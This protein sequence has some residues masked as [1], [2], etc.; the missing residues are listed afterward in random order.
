MRFEHLPQLSPA[1]AASVKKIL[2]EC[3]DEFVPPLSLRTATNSAQLVGGPG[4]TVGFEA[5]YASMAKQAFVLAYDEA[6]DELLAFLTYIPKAKVSYFEGDCAYVST[7]C[8]TA[9]ARGK[10]IAAALYRQLEDILGAGDICLKT[11]STN[12]AQIKILPRLGYQ[13][14]K[15]VSNERGEGIDSVYFHKAL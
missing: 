15:R 3:Q 10:G 4:A 8:T 2:H 14:F 6:T 7:V 12:I 5:Y 1:A 11:W 13:E 9:R